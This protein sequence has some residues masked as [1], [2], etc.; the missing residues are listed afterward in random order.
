M[1]AA[2]RRTGSNAR[3]AVP[4]AGFGAGTVN[5]LSLKPGFHESLAVLSFVVK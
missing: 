3:A 4:P 5:R 2:A 1:F